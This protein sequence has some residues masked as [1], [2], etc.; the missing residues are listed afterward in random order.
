MLSD[1][2]GHSTDQA[3][4]VDVLRCCHLTFLLL[5]LSIIV[6]K[7]WACESIRNGSGPAVVGDGEQADFVRFTAATMHWPFED[8]LYQT[9]KAR[10]TNAR[11]L[12]PKPKLQ[13]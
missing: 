8:S 11:L 4:V 5:T 3:G 12:Q 10:T 9:I 2:T 6:V 7:L 13:R 1:V